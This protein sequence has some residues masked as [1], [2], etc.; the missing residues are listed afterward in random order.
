MITE[1][2]NVLVKLFEEATEHDAYYQRADKK[3][4]YPY[5][6][7]DIRRISID[8]GIGK[9]VLEVNCWDHYDTNS[10]IVKMMEDIE[11]AVHKQTIVTEFGSMVIYKG[12]WD[13]IEDDNKDIKRIREQM[14]MQV[15]GRRL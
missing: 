9:Y 10:R 6:V 11:N 12:P 4:E 14:E 13:P 7:F 3:A 8:S 2:R 5:S 15:V 1:L